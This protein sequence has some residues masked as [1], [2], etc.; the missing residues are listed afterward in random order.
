[1]DWPPTTHWGPQLVQT[2]VDAGKLEVMYT[3][4]GKQY[5]T[6]QQLERE[7]L[8]ELFVRGGACGRCRRHHFFL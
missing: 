8:D 3:T 7:I 6:P 2:L 4:D 1:M 5:V